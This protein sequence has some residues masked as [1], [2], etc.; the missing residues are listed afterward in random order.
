VWDLRARSLTAPERGAAAAAGGGAEGPEP[1][2][3]GEP[4]AGGGFGGFGGFGGGGGALRVEPGTYTVKV[5]LGKM[6]QSKTITVEEDPRIVISAEDRSA[7][8]QALAQL[9]QMMATATTAQRSMTGLR[10]SLSNFLEG[11]K[12]P[13]AAKLPENVQ[14]AAEELL[15]KTEE[16]CKKFAAP[17]QCGERGPGRGAAGPP[18][19]FVPPAINQRLGQ[20]LGGIENYTAAPTAWQL[21]QIKLLQGLLSDANGAAKK[22]TQEDL[23]ALN[24]MMNDAG[25]PH[26]SVP[27][28]GRARGGGPPDEDPVEE[29]IR[30]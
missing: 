21:D 11:A 18:L 17:A 19:V 9:G 22:L 5:A 4:P 8:R 15:K 28:G 29:S 2:E 27:A 7:R 14:K 12:R 1:A 3:A 10:T 25:V 30:P 23:P 13:G 6:E 16:T 24:K 20:L 26:I